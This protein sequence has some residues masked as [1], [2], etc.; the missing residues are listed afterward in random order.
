MKKISYSGYRFPP[1][2]IQ[3]AIWLYLRF[4]LSF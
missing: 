2:I 3:Q 1:V 4:T